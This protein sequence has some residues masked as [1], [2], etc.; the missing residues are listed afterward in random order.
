MPDVKAVTLDFDG[1]IFNS[2]PQA[3]LIF[4]G[5]IKQFNGPF[6]NLGEDT[7]N[8]LIRNMWGNNGKQL[9]KWFL[10]DENQD[11]LIRMWREFENTMNPKPK[12]IDGFY[13]ACKWLKR[14][15]IVVALLTNR[16]A[17]ALNKHTHHFKNSLENIFDCVQTCDP[18]Q[19]RE[20]ILNPL[21]AKQ[22][23]SLHDNHLSSSYLKP[24][25][26][27][28]NP[29][30]KWLNKHY[31]IKKEEVW[32]VGDTP[33]DYRASFGAKIN[34]LGVLTGPLNTKKRWLE[35]CPGMKENQIIESIAQL[36]LFIKNLKI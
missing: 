7:L 23:L 29:L 5:F 26:K 11:E 17:A 1:T 36:P 8:L 25:P 24:D 18:D 12:I 2:W 20:K 13:P 31:K 15:S 4:K 10:P 6:Q 35:W 33:V 9:L 22:P 28:F 34:F 27:V 32:Y 30:I 16:G 21:G 3:Y 14:N 19:Q